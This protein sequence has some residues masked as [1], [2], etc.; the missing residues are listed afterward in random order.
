MIDTLFIT[1]L[2]GYLLELVH[3]VGRLAG[4]PA[5]QLRVRGRV[6]QGGALLLQQPPRIRDSL[7]C[8]GVGLGLL[9]PGLR[10]LEHRADGVPGGERPEAAAVTLLPLEHHRGF[11]LQLGLQ[12]LLATT[13]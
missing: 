12:R 5:H 10:T 3:G 2:S 1:T 13:S 7:G 4:P 11:L 8:L 6:R 9:G